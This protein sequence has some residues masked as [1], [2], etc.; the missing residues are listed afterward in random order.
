MA[1]AQGAETI[2][3]DS[4]DPI[5]ALREL[6]KGIGPDRAIDAVGVDAEKSR[7]GDGNWQPGDS[8]SLALQWCVEA[9]A[10][11]GRVS[12]V[13][14]YPE[15]VRFFPIGTAMNKN[16]TL[17]MGNCNHRKY[18]PKLLRLLQSHAVDPTPFLARKTPLA[19]AIDAYEEFDKRSPHWVKVELLPVG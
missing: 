1:R 6:T 10:K 3:F 15:A 9:V 4:E 13:G 18:I 16:L 5:D 2:D 14:V 11:A 8:P 19:S 12:I 7:N 17:R